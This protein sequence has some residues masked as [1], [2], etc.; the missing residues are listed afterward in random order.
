LK[1][2]KIMLTMQ[3]NTL[4]TE[5]PAIPG[6]AFRGFAGESDYP[7]MLAVIEA[8]KHADKVERSDTLDDI[9]RNYSHLTNCDPY[10]DM[11]FA[12][13]NGEVI[14]Y[15]RVWWE[16]LEDGGLLYSVVGFLHPD[17]RRKRIGTAML[18]HAE[19]RMRQI[20]AEHETTGEKLFQVWANE[21]E[22]SLQ[23]LLE[24]QGY[25][26]ARYFFEMTRDINMPLPAAPLPPG[27]EV[28]PVTEAHYRSIF[29]AANEAFRDHW[30]FVDRT[31]EEEFPHWIEDPDFNPSL[32]K[33][34]WD[35]D[36]IAGMVQNFVNKAENAEYQ[37]KRGYTEGIS[38]RRPW[39]KLGLARSL[40]VQSIA[41]FKEMGMDETALGVDAENLSGALK[42]YQGVGYKEVKRN[43]SYRKPLD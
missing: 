20:A 6:L 30:G 17:W 7:K 15:N 43:M 25:R 27:L 9:R 32:W 11:L 4:L 28:R 23:A 2:E 38:V 16:K 29:E 10:T 41:M 19:A 5:S 8:S 1:K 36:Q 13:I 22:Q 31:F 3:E 37:R 14:G 26:P 40:L 42:L 39:R 33:V 18:Q 12:E 24:N 21:S 34:A 35:G